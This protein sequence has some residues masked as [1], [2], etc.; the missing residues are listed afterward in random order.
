MT[1]QLIGLGYYGYDPSD[2]HVA[3]ENISTGSDATDTDTPPVIFD[4][5]M[6]SE[7]H[8][9]NILK[10]QSVKWVSGH[11]QERIRITTLKRP[12]IRSCSGGR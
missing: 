8:R 2:Y 10:E 5:L 4:D 1:D 6:H 12:F 9:E 11:G 7:G 3:G